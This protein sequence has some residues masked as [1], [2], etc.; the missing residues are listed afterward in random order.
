MDGENRA[1]QNDGRRRG[2]RGGDHPGLGRGGTSGLAAFPGAPPPPTS[3]LHRHQLVPSSPAPGGWGGAG[4]DG[5]VHRPTHACNGGGEHPS[6]PPH[7][8]PTPGDSNG[9]IEGRQPAR[10]GVAGGEEEERKLQAGDPGDGGKGTKEAARW[11]RR[12]GRP[13]QPVEWGLARGRRGQGEG[14]GRPGSPRIVVSPGQQPPGGRAIE[15]QCPRGPTLGSLGRR[16]RDGRD[17]RDPGRPPARPP[18]R[19]PLGTHI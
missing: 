3:P 18:A 11:G 12:P 10:G 13:G 2:A 4:G 16:G 9:V 8:P 15:T 1:P 7:P 6:F 5:T 14:R 17:R 19:P